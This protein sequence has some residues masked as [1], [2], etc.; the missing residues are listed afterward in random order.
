MSHADALKQFTG[1]EVAIIGMSGR[2]PKAKSV[3][4]FWRNLR[5]GLDAVSRLTPEETAGLGLTPDLMRDNHYVNAAYVLDDVEMFDAAFF[6]INPREAEIIDP[7][8][9]LFLECAWEAL[10]HAGYD[11][12]RYEGAIGVYG[13]AKLS[14]YLMNLYGEGGPAGALSRVQIIMGNDTDHLTTRVSY[15]LNLKGPSIN[16]QTT[17]STSLVAVH[18]ACQSL[19][20]G[21]CDMALAGGVAVTVPQKTGYFYQEG[22]INSPDGRCRAFDAGAMGTV[23]GNGAGI[24]V[25][26]R[27]ADA[28][29]DGDHVHAVIRGSAINNDGSLKVGYT[30]PSVEGQAKVIAEALAMAEVEPETISYVEAHGTGTTLG[31]PIEIAALTKAFRAGTQRNGFCAIGSVKSSVGHLDTAAG[32]AG[33]IKTVLA[34]KHQEIPA[35]L[36][37]ERPNP[38]I[39]FASTPFFV[40]HTLREWEA[41]DTPRR[42]GVSSFGIGGTNTHVVVEE[43]PAA[44]PSGDSRPWQ[45]LTLSARTSSAL[46][47]ATEN[48]AEHLRQNPNAKLADVAYTLQVGRRAFS[49]R[50]ALVCRDAADALEAL[51]E[52]GRGRVF[53]GAGLRG[54]APPVAFMFP[55]QGAQYVGMG[56]ELYE[57]EETFRAEV[58]RCTELLKPHLGADLRD[59]LY[60]RE[61]ERDAVERRISQTAYTQPALFVVEY[62]LARLWMAW[63]VRPQSFVGHSV[64]E[65]V[66]AC[67]SGVMS[68]EDALSLVAAR[69][70]L[71]Q[72]LPG[73]VM[74]GVP[75]GEAE[76]EALLGPGLSLAAVNSP[77]LCV[78]A[79]TPEA[80][81]GLEERLRARGVE[82]RRLHTSHAFHSE[83]M[84]PILEPFAELVR[85]LRLQPPRL[86]YVSNVTGTWVTAAEA[87]DAGYWARHLRRTVRFADG[88][89]V[90]LKEGGRVLL[91]VG[92]G[93]TLGTLVQG[94]AEKSSA[95]VVFDSLPRP[96]AKA[97][98]LE[99]V[100]KTLGRLWA[101]GVEVD[102]K[103]F[104][105]DERRARLPLPT[106]PFERQRFWVG[107]PEGGAAR[108]A[109]ANGSH[110]EGD[111]GAVKS[112]AQASPPALEEASAPR[113]AGPPPAESGRPA[114]ARLQLVTR[115][116]ALMSQ[117]LELLRRARANDGNT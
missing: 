107:R 116:L 50:R 88:V 76:V 40:N 86:P 25:L 109:R 79:G 10:E 51:A 34:L 110:A 47:A 17:C 14:T 13:G 87:T 15:K 81:G 111:G 82:G 105:A 92:P 6:G 26:K 84:E 46:D 73:G 114:E 112:V 64:G 19:L 3:E 4:A 52:A 57:T 108:S 31:D 12:E 83:M 1:S 22:N 27:L 69:G 62:A 117:Q 36:H 2:F 93:R 54:G 41:A 74:L 42:A 29:A 9:R 43:S 75:L 11:P 115:Q 32:V 100:L 44:A 89:G 5:D 49:H 56:A 94:Q 45:L 23:G 66:A 20:N 53:T 8:H 61:G 68:L 39:D 113:A 35:S 63:G 72:Q 18:L 33:L 80:V 60:P 104:Y 95:P 70:R 97:S 78:V 71:M 65:Y 96:N 16:V 7:Q 106:Y 77:R 37:F 85:G 28:L 103:G 91:E 58:D 99:H 38:K 48:L 67:L 101:A 55:G 59:T 98:D 21:E 102:W 90:L 30:A 24:V